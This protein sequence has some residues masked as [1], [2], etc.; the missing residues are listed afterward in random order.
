M[1][2]R[3]GQQDFRKTLESLPVFVVMDYLYSK[4]D[5]SPVAMNKQSA[6]KYRELTAMFEQVM[7]E[8]AAKE[9]VEGVREVPFTALFSIS[10]MI[11]YTLVKDENFMAP[12]MTPEYLCSDFPSHCIN[13]AFIS[14][15]IGMGLELSFQEMGELGV[16]ALLH[17]IGMTRIHPAYYEHDR[18][19]SEEERKVVESHPQA[20]HKFLE[21]LDKDFPWLLR[22]ILEEHQ[23]TGEKGYPL[24]TD[25]EP[26]VYSKIIGM[27]DS[28]EALT[29]KRSFRKAYH[30]GDAVKI[31]IEGKNTLYDKRVLRAMLESISLFPVGSLVQL[32]TNTIAEVIRSNEGSPLRPVVRMV[33]ADKVNGRGEQRVIDLTKEKSLFITGLVYDERYFI[34]DQAKAL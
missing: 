28:F 26:H 3:P 24:A 25:E 14:C 19:L 7:N 15:T 23:R 12:V 11:L 16:A 9:I 21:K 6:Q 5:N 18:L 1:A 34:P 22:V 32:N 30:P 31:I 2:R 8:T 27:V 10:E 17:D 13:V 29:H 20:G 4:N 33:E